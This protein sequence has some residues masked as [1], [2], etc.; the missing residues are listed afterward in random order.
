VGGGESRRKKK[1]GLANRKRKKKGMLGVRDF[2]ENSLGYERGST[3]NLGVI[4]RAVNTG[5]AT[6]ERL[7][8]GT[9][10]REGQRLPEGTITREEEQGYA[11][12]SAIE[13]DH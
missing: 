5:S 4:E 9:V 6:G 7:F 10:N 11:Q 13:K 8:W 1:G 12:L 2:Y 3:R